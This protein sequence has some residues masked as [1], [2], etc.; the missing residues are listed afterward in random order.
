MVTDI[1]TDHLIVIFY[2]KGS[3]K[4]FSM[5]CHT[6]TFC[7]TSAQQL[8]V[9]TLVCDFCDE[10]K[11]RYITMHVS[12]L[13]N[14]ESDIFGNCCICEWLPGC[15]S[16]VWPTFC[17]SSYEHGNVTLNFNYYSTWI[18]LMEVTEVSVG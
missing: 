18:D 3:T 17:L 14:G 5:D 10:I 16:C 13:E 12:A 4:A 15:L 2:M 9:F 7:I 11:I 6:E 1:F 8:L